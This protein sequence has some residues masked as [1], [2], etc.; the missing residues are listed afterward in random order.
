MVR[1]TKGACMLRKLLFA[2][3]L[4]ITIQ[5]GA[6]GGGSSAGPAA[7]V[8]LKCGNLITPDGSVIVGI[9]NPEL[10]FYKKRVQAVLRNSAAGSSAEW[11]LLQKT[12]VAPQPDGSTKYFYQSSDRKITFFAVVLPDPADSSY[13]LISGALQYLGASAQCPSMPVPVVTGP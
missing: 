9:N 12:D 7:P 2:A 4:L 10:N 8:R 5:S 13:E 6:D 1:S 3:T 11:T